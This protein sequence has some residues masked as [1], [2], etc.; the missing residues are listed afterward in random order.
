MIDTVA[1]GTFTSLFTIKNKT[2]NKID[3]KDMQSQVIS[4]L[5][6]KLHIGFYCF[7]NNFISRI[8]MKLG[9]G[10]SIYNSR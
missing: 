5:W 10:I 2:P 4:S 3:N 1:N 8:N 6:Y 9:G 7:F